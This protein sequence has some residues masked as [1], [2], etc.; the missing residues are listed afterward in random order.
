MQATTFGIGPF[1][2]AIRHANAL[3]VA[4]RAFETEDQA[5]ENSLKVANAL[6]TM[7]EGQLLESGFFIRK[8]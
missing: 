4:K 5:Y 1:F 6:M 3:Y 2:A 8:G 7:V